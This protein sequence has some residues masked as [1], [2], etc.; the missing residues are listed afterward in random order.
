MKLPCGCCSG[1]EIATPQSEYNRP[2]LPALSYRVGTY[3]TFFESMLARLSSLALDATAD[4]GSGTVSRLYP[5]KGLTTRELN[6]PSIALLD[7]WAV[8]SDV[9]TFYQERIANEGYLPTAIERR[10][11]LELARL[12]GYRLRPGVASSVFLAFTVTS[13][14]KGEIPV[15]TRAQ[16]VPN[17]GETAQFFETSDELY[18]RD[19][20]NALKPRLTRPQIITPVPDPALKVVNH[21]G[22]N[23]DV[24]DTLFLQGVATNLKSGDGLV[25]VFGDDPGEQVLRF[26]QD[27]DLDADHSR[28]R[29]V[30]QE[31]LV[32][33]SSSLR[34]ALQRFVDDAATSFDGSDLA[35]QAAA[36]VE[37]VLAGS[38]STAGI[39]PAI[40]TLQAIA[41]RRGF[42]RLEPWLG[43]LLEVLEENSSN[44]ASFGNSAG[45]T[46]SEGPLPLPNL[47]VS[48]L[49][50]LQNLVTPLATPPS[51]QPANPLVLARSVASAF[52]PQSD[53]VPRLITALQP[54]ITGEALYRAWGTSQP[55]PLRLQI[56]AQRIKATLF[57]S[58]FTGLPSYTNNTPS[59]TGVNVAIST[60]WTDLNLG[61]LT[62]LRFVALDGVYDKIKR[63]SWVAVERPAVDPNGNVIAGETVFSYHKV[64]KV[65]TRS[66]DTHTGY[67]AKSTI[68]TLDSAWLTGGTPTGGVQTLLAKP[69]ILRETIVYAQS[70]LQS[71][72]EEP[73]DHDVSGSTIELDG[74]FDELEPGKWAVVTGART[75]V[76]NVT[77]LI[78]SELVM[79]SAVSQGKG[80]EFCRPFLPS[81]IPFQALF[82][83]S[84]AN[85]AGDRLVVGRPSPDF[86]QLLQQIALPEF[87]GQEF[88]EHVQL[89]PGLFA[90]AYIPTA[91][92]RKGEFKDFAQQLI[93]PNAGGQ[94]FP[95]GVIPISRQSSVFAWRIR[96]ISS[97]AET[98]HTTIELAG[99][100]AYTYDSTTVSIA[101][102]VVNATNGQTIGE[103]LGDGNAAQAF[104]TFALRK[105]PLTYV[106]SST[107]AGIESTLD[108]TVNEI[109]WAE[110]GDPAALGPNDR[111]YTTQTDND[112]VVSVVFGNGEHGARLPTGNSNVKATYRYGIGS[113]G[114]VKAGQ[115]SQLATHPLGPQSVINPLDATGGADR[116]TVD[117]VR[118]NAPTAVLALDRLVSVQDYADF[119]RT[120]AGIDKAVSIRISDGRQQFVHV[121]IA[122][123]NDIPID[124]SS[125]LFRNLVSALNQYG[126]P[127]QPVQV[128]VRKRKLI[129]LSAGVRLLPGYHWEAVS[130]VVTSALL[131]TFSFDRRDLAQPAFLSEAIA[132]MQ[133]V[134]GVA[135]VDIDV[136][137]SVSD[138]ASVKD[139]AQLVSTLTL[140]DFIPAAAARLNPAWDPNDPA[141]TRFIGAELV[142]M[143]PDIPATVILSQIG[144]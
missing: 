89:S 67:A 99:K 59:F 3:A 138:D 115:I 113:A 128:S 49:N 122:G 31:A 63:G 92:E 43:H 1:I 51:V 84:D 46:V 74:L 73:I 34:D 144:A 132:A 19:D 95:N 61:N 117:Q 69:E 107:P 12:V 123:V 133:A 16:S 103:V 71:L 134:E 102:N 111:A 60:T 33:A 38:Q 75:D 135:Y 119:A 110:S 25:I 76:P 11:L 26:A 23:A 116:D 90:D 120:F 40:R 21:L 78:A 121:T 64:A 105:S 9:L 140:R 112:D 98:V 126:D 108:V 72:S 2:G 93:D 15:G 55:N 28:T 96:N 114:N 54:T 30:L 118:S 109:D 57:A 62:E 104:Q 13:G 39:I 24:V 70:E 66:L 53:T 131:D 42:L 124:Q 41:V 88:C 79:I 100:L 47:S 139:L 44:F 86:R 14:F 85:V 136:F 80:K 127:F 20:W 29:V 129:V 130:P 37:S 35:A 58:S 77:G 27:V 106:S 52:A 48:S 36:A 143:T 50:Q 32:V 81:V 18:A 142:F 87:P 10:S 22:T 125:D 68:L 141:S 101:A 65:Q 8:V 7:A 17:P 94:T 45:G 97:G 91:A 6:D 56:F 82:Y 83:I 4:D 137:D 5:L